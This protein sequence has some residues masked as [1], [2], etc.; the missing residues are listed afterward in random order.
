MGL[1]ARTRTTVIPQAWITRGLRRL[2]LDA[3]IEIVRR[4]EKAEIH[5]KLKQ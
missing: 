5:T 1:S 2:Q 4:E 3:V